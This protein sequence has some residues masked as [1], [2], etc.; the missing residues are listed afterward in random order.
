MP[1]SKQI[2]I[3]LIRGAVLHKDTHVHFEFLAG[4]TILKPGCAS[5]MFNSL[6]AQ[7]RPNS[8]NMLLLQ[9]DGVFQVLTLLQCVESLLTGFSWLHILCLLPSTSNKPN[10]RFRQS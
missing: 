9:P 8:V 10:F 3:Q 4:L 2:G 6:T 5:L 7:R 1:M